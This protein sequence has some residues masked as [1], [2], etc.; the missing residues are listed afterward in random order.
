MPHDHDHSCSGEA[1]DH[2]HD[3]DHHG[4]AQTDPADN[5]FPYIDR[6]NVIALNCDV[7]NPGMKVIKPWHERRDES[8]F[9]ESDADDQMIVR[10]PFSGSVNLHSVLLKCGPGDQTAEK[11][12]LFAN[13]DNLDFSDTAG[14]KPSQVFDNVPQSTEVGEYTVKRAIFSNVSSITL[15]F[16]G[17]QGAENLRIYYIGMRGIW[18][19]RKREPVIT[20]YET[21][22]NLADHEK[23][24]GTDSGMSGMRFGA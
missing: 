10:I 1:H 5:L 3:H 6:S 21:Q 14:E 24:Q 18:S 2:D 17:A 13:K 20:V 11:I 12:C 23:I 19:E 4:S 22:A 15:F 7:D 8:Q 9:I 16:P